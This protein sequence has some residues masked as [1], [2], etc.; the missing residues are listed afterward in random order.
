VAQISVNQTMQN[1]TVLK[2]GNVTE[3][4]FEPIVNNLNAAREALQGNF[5]QTAFNLLNYLVW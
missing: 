1:Q 5:D 3:E 2:R 4:D